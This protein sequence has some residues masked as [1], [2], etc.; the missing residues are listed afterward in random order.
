MTLRRKLTALCMMAVL[1]YGGGAGPA[2]A[3]GNKDRALTVMTRNMYHGTTFDE[4]FAAQSQSELLA[5]VAEAF[6]E[7]EAGH[8]SARVAAIA[9][10]IAATQPVLVGLQEVALWKTGP[11]DPQTPAD[12]VAFDFLQLLIDDLAARGLHYAPVA[13][14]NNFTAEA[15]A[16]GPTGL[17][18][19][20]F[21]DR[22]AVLA[23]TDAKVSQLKV[24][25]VE[26]HHFT[27][28]LPLSNPFLG[29]LTIL[30]G[31]IAV[32]AKMR[33]KTYRFVD[34]HLESFSP[35]VQFVQAH[36]LLQ[37]AGDTGRP[38]VLAGDFNADAEGSDPT[39]QLL[40]SGGFTD[41]WDATHPNEPGYTWPLFLTNPFTYVAPVQRLDLV[42]TR[43]AIEA[44][45]ARIVGAENVTPARPLPSDHA[46]V[47]AT[48][49]LLP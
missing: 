47:V 2:Q 37:T 4:I 5:E 25:S 8:V 23:R 33:G 40:L 7:V 17:F 19:V 12:T 24:E 39:Y 32:D 18:D 14:L 44:Q 31:W 10:E 41:A 27:T 35:L 9:D 38:V 30:R 6:A 43:G 3:A 11:F 16:F 21:T 28:N 34:A 48:L 29:N 15:P 13:V 45:A 36:E 42:L 1:L 46:G 22:L 20:S 49:R 26:A